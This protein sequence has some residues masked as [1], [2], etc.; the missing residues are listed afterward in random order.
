MAF[1]AALLLAA[2]AAGGAQRPAAS[3]PSAERMQ[4][5]ER[6]LA[7]VDP[8]R[9]MND[10][11]YAGEIADHLL[12]LRTRR[13]LDR[14]MRYQLE[15]LLAL[16][17]TGAGRHDEAEASADAMIRMRPAAAGS[18]MGAFAAA[19]DAE[20]WVRAVLVVERGEQALRDRGERAEFVALYERE[21]VFW[22][23][24][25]LESDRAAKARLAAALLRLGWP[26]PNEPSQTADPLRMIVLERHLERGEQ[27]DAARL[28][29]EI[30]S[31]GEVLRLVTQ[32][33][34]DPV[35]SEA[36]RLAR[37]RAAIEAED[38][39]T[40]AALAAAPEDVDA[41]VNRAA[42]LR[43]IGR[44]QAVLDLLLPR[45]ADPSLVVAR[46]ERGL[47]LVNEA[48]Y[49]LITTGAADEAIELM[50]P[51]A[52]MDLRTNPGLVN[53]SINFIHMLL[54][55]GRNEE[56][57]RQ[58]E[59][60]DAAPDGYV[61]DYG[62]MIVW[63]NAACAAAALGRGAESDRWVARMEAKVDEN[64][65]SMLQARLCRSETEAAE[66]V[67]IGA[68]ES[69]RWRGEA[70][71]WM[72]DWAS[73]PETAASQRLADRFAELRA[74]PSVEAAFARIGRRLQLPLPSTVY[75]F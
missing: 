22:L 45:M 64:R 6:A 37:V 66:R 20:R 44:D 75:G 2:P 48:A 13:G 1:A 34:F 65:S 36:D 58:A 25:R 59:R 67:L 70:V 43:S 18:W 63:G 46:G 56:A 50:R 3:A 41:G 26:G 51:V 57:L 54:K 32:R 30:S 21:R 33:R 15:T 42:F 69:E 19:A 28:A 16:A 7:E 23:L 52:A 40:A 10:R 74:R 11:A 9:V 35:I 68:L 29:V 60:V 12:V 55:S 27:S 62:K 8:D 71:L 61:S 47:W 73:R 14:D 49:S 53:T 72:Q 38:R 39:A 31:V 5:A 24:R 17:F 4:Q